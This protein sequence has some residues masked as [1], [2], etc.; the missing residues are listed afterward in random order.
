MGY[1]ST[2]PHLPQER[3][4]DAVRFG[5]SSDRSRTIAVAYICEYNHRPAGNGM[6]E[7]D[8]VADEWVRTHPDVRIQRMAD[9]FLQSYL[10]RNHQTR[11]A[12]A[13]A[14]ASE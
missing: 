5:V 8:R 4:C 6:L 11:A 10:S 13:V 2:C 3:T 12:S 14:N 7:Y 9:C 1:A